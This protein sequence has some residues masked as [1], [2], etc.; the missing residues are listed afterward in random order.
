M[1]DVGGKLFNGIKSMYV[2]SLACVRVKEGESE[3]FRIDSAVRQGCMPSWFFNVY[4]DA[5]MKEVKIG[6]GRKEVRFLEDEREWKLPGLL[7]AD[8]LV[9]CRI[10]P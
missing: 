1:Y 6:I 3:R 7:Y 9:L 4:M 5:E 10:Y 8:C 2:G